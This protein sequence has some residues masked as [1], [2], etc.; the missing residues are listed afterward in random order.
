MP[1]QSNMPLS[2]A[3]CTVQE[4]QCPLWEHCLRSKVYREQF[5]EIMLAPA[6]TTVNFQSPKVHAL[7]EQCTYFRS[8]RPQRFA[9]GM[10]HI[11]D[12]VPKA[13]Y[14]AVQQAVE[15]C[16]GC[17][18]T[19]FYCKKGEQLITPK[20]QTAIAAVFLRHGF[21]E[22]PRFDAYEECYSWE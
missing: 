4:G 5:N 8:D 21:I 14:S 15:F 17:R 16:F 22:P 19:Y 6:I 20:E 1:Q 9:R 2:Y 7:T 18:R 11:F 12:A 10:K 13:K 3:C